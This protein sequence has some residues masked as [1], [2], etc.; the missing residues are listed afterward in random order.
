MKKKASKPAGHTKEEDS[1][2]D[3]IRTSFFARYELKWIIPI[4]VV[5]LLIFANS[6]SGEFV[7]DDLRQILRNP[8]IQDNSL[9]WRALTSDVW[10]FKG[11]GTI[12]ASNYW[13]PTFTAW[14]IL[15]YRLFGTDPY[16]WHI[17]NLVLHAGVSVLA[18]ALLR[19]WQF[20]A[21]I[22][23]AIALIFAVHPIHVESV[24]W[25]SGSP[26][27]LF[28]LAFLGSLWFAQNYTEKTPEKTGA[29]DLI[30]SLALYAVALGA[31]EIGIL[32]LPVYYLVLSNKQET[33]KKTR[34]FGLPLLSY[35][36]VAAV[37]FIARIGVLG[38]ISRP[39]ENATSFGDAVLSIPAMFAFY[40]RQTFFPYWLSANYPLQPVS[41]IGLLNFVL[42]L[43]IMLAVLVAVFYLARRSQAAKIG[44]LLFLLPLLPAMNATAFIPDQI[45]HDR[46]L[47]L[48][49]LGILM[50][51]LPLATGFLK[52]QYILLISAALSVLLCFQT[53]TYNTAWAN[54]LALWS[55]SSK[56]DNSSFTL[57][58]YGSIL[59]DK[60][61]HDEAIQAYSDSLNTKSSARSY[62]GRG[63]SYLAKKQYAEAEKDLT[64]VLR[65]PQD[66]LDTYALYQT[67]EA[68]G[69][70]Y[71]EQKKLDEAIK[72]FSEG[73]RILPIY[74]VSLTVNLA[75]VLYQKGQKEEALR[76][77]E[78]YRAK[79]RKEL[80]P[81]A[82]SLF[83]RLGLLYAELGKKEEAR[84]ALKEHL[85]QT[86]SMKD[87]TTAAER[88][89]ANKALQTLDN[90]QPQQKTITIPL[91]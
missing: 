3:E 80:L 18:Y 37:Y 88:T 55:W 12:A 75:I 44:A 11:D 54:D 17:L 15:N 28:A 86:A 39:P 89:Q 77:L 36:A 69:I 53:F 79:A 73:R 33:D 72:N 27:L 64:T 21:M 41:S 22:A 5:C 6:L 29:R 16:G 84:S 49:L 7:Y 32:C 30:F 19:R 42:P 34:P 74:S 4:A 2:K 68:L 56:I 43:L 35:L 81:E 78:S 10:A 46:Y 38:A 87:N 24:A 25:V 83:L 58:Q 47:Y 52:E 50:L 91:K 31:K 70:S 13:R 63:R 40:L 71:G 66:K 82:K 90:P 85:E 48:P 76:E 67:Y 60:G 61:R 26:D 65:M 20:S 62:L 23:C 51:L 45:V 9:I 57:A 8:L 59:A 1:S 14:H